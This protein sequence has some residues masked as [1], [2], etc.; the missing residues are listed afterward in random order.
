MKHFQKSRNIIFKDK[1][2]EDRD[3]DKDR[4]R[5]QIVKATI[6]KSISNIDLAD[7]VQ[8]ADEDTTNFKSETAPPAAAVPTP[9]VSITP[10][11]DESLFPKPREGYN[12]KKF[13]KSDLTTISSPDTDV[14]KSLDDRQ[15]HTN[16]MPTVLSPL[17][18]PEVI[19]TVTETPVT[20]VKKTA[21]IEKPLSETKQIPSAENSIDVESGINLNADVKT[22]EDHKLT[23]VLSIGSFDASPSESMKTVT[24]T[25]PATM[26][27]RVTTE[28]APSV[29]KPLTSAESLK[30][31]ESDAKLNVDM[32]IDN[33]L[34]NHLPPEVVVTDITPFKSKS[35]IAGDKPAEQGPPPTPLFQEFVASDKI[36]IAKDDNL[37]LPVDESKLRESHENILAP[38]SEIK[39]PLSSNT[40][41]VPPSENEPLSLWPMNNR[42][43]SRLTEL[44]PQTHFEADNGKKEEAE[45]QSEFAFKRKPTMFAINRDEIETELKKMALEEEQEEEQITLDILKSLVSL[46][47]AEIQTSQV[48]IHAT[49]GEESSQPGTSNNR[50]KS[51]AF[52]TDQHKLDVDIKSE[53]D[54]KYPDITL[55]TELPATT[56]E[57]ISPE[58]IHSF[59][60]SVTLDD[61]SEK[62]GLELPMGDLSDL[63][64]KSES[65]HKKLFSSKPKSEPPPGPEKQTV[66]PVDNAAR[67]H[68]HEDNREKSDNTDM[69]T[70]LH[71]G[72]EDASKFARRKSTVFDVN[73]EEIEAQLNMLAEESGNKKEIKSNISQS[74]RPVISEKPSS[75]EDRRNSN[76]YTVD[77]YDL[78]RETEGEEV[79]DNHDLPLTKENFDKIPVKATENISSSV[80]SFKVSITSD[81]TSEKD[82][83]EMPIGDLSDHKIKTE[84]P[85]KKLFSLKPKSEL[86]PGPEK[87]AV[88]PIDNVVSDLLHKDNREMSDNIDMHTHFEADEGDVSKF[89]ARRKSTVYGVDKD[90]IE[91]E[92]DMLAEESENKENIKSDIPQS[93]RAEIAEEGTSQPRS[94][95]DRRKSNIYTVDTFDLSKATEDEEATEYQDLPPTKKNFDQQHVKATENISS[96]GTHSFKGSVPLDDTFE[97]D[98]PLELPIGDFSEP[99]MKTESPYEKLLSLKPKSESPSG[100][101]KQAVNPIDNIVRGHLDEEHREKSD[102]IKI[103]PQTHFDTPEDEM[104][105]KFTARHKSTIFADPVDAELELIAQ[106]EEQEREREKELM[107]SGNTKSNSSEKIIK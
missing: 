90:E 45:Y 8:D 88:D 42:K 83:L 55:V 40:Q 29:V 60:G 81:D 10:L 107:K 93:F 84:L 43:I 13:N 99:N 79:T 32:E 62:D 102:K 36:P 92:L 105:T 54:M 86:P 47:S 14:A 101:E 63:K 20:S 106:M 19:K 74:F 49:T 67:D 76:I 75:A 82:G 23:E 18:V 77:E 31:L 48:A 71:A 58:Y 61:T 85:H 15:K 78:A 72:E 22:T 30:D 27:D 70:H 73:K 104:Q 2:D 25:A 89:T 91:A 100:T 97:K 12:T 96:S 5:V 103:P 11:V 87:Q 66:D 24:A 3:Q 57:K 98:G 21:T 16:L 56:A 38:K 52:A 37:E 17:E 64:I 9:P 68:E 44:H 65:P 6:V 33:T 1:D 46:E 34:K 4:K 51:T 80:H 94:S 53:D 28:K 35:G 7:S 39:P 50:R 41:D 95:N 26:L 59:K 69:H